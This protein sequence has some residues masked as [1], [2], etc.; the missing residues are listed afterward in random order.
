M[1]KA[2]EENYVLFRKVLLTTNVLACFKEILKIFTFNF[3][4]T[5]NF[6]NKWIQQTNNKNFNKYHKQIIDLFYGYFYTL[7]DIFIDNKHKDYSSCDYKCKKCSGSIRNCTCIICECYKSH[8]NR[9][10][11][12]VDYCLKQ[13]YW[14]CKRLNHGCKSSFGYDETTNNEIIE[15]FDTCA[16]TGSKILKE[17]NI[18][19]CECATCICTDTEKYICIGNDPISS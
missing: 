3:E 4:P 12:I 1:H 13:K 11:K 17:L 15:H 5:G 6:L 10:V 16:R 8:K 18:I 9:V 7:E 19:K 14:D 2:T